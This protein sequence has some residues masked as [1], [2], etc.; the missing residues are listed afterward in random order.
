M[1]DLQ[2]E[3][4]FLH[5]SG[6]ALEYLRLGPAPGDAP[7]L[8]L[9]HEGLG[10]VSLWKYFPE[11]L[12]RATGMGVLAYSRAGYGGSDPSP[13]PRPLSF[14]HSEGLTVLPQVLNA[15]GIRKAVLVGHSDGAS[16]AL[17]HAGGSGDERVKGLV[18]MAPHVLVEEITL[19]GIRAAGEAYEK[20]GLRQ[21]LQSHHGDNVDGA[22]LG[23]HRAW[24]DPGFRW[25]NLES[26][27]P[28]IQVPVLLIQGEE[29]NYGSVLQLE[30]IERR[31]PKKPEILLLAAC[32]HAPFR[33]QPEATIRAIAAFVARCS[34]APNSFCVG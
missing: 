15:A 7:T 5:I 16:I 13:L 12:A 2:R 33:D 10:C 17:I 30:T 27:L 29:D 25:W 11:Q 20:T 4:G 21:R 9:L 32:G 18:L 3:R 14:M 26:F 31:L 1:S 19:A 23:W 22:F 24:L 6:I 28:A 8:V 34:L